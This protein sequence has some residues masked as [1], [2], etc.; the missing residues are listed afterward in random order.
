MWKEE[1]IM[2]NVNMLKGKLVEKGITVSEI[3]KQLNI[4]QSTFYRKM[5]NNSFRISET[6]VIVN[7]LQLSADEASNIFFSQIVA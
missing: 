1:Q 3:A 6:D 4:N 7:V 5:K 2:L